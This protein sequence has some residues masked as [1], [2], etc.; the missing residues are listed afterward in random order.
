MLGR[1]VH[2]KWV[3]AILAV[4]VAL[5][6]AVPV[7]AGDSG[8]APVSWPADS[9]EGSLR[10]TQVPEE[11][12]FTVYKVA[13]MTSHGYVEV[14]ELT[15]STQPVDLTRL[16]KDSRD[17]ANTLSAVVAEAHLT[18][19]VDG[20]QVQEVRDGTTVLLADHLTAG[21]YLVEGRTVGS[22][23]N[24][25]RWLVSVP[26]W[27]ENTRAWVYD[28]VAEVTK[29]SVPEKTKN[30]RVIKVWR[31]NRTAAFHKAVTVSILK[32]GQPWKTV[33]LEN[34]NNWTYSW[35][36]GNEEDTFSV[37]EKS[38]AE[39]YSA[40]V[41]E[42]ALDSRGGRTFTITNREKGTYTPPP[43]VTRTPPSGFHETPKNSTPSA[44]SKLTTMV[45]TGD[46]GGLMTVMCIMASAGIVLILTGLGFN[47]RK[48]D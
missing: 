29:F 27:D 34:A 4:L 17:L 13:D 48:E 9:H 28:V 12:V 33:T 21:L 46:T 16:G 5:M 41:T 8:V 10:V 19:V 18:P 2:K 20:K 39:G 36:S 11:T 25:T 38:G 44:G 6:G 26:Q 3:V 47:R 45:R 37:A 42:G 43:S 35:S 14:G 31:D 15:K 7:I 32:N 22:S 40:I 1:K 30:W 23:R 24:Y